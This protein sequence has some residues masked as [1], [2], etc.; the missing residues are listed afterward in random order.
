MYS[1]INLVRRASME[2]M[3]AGLRGRFNCVDECIC[4]CIRIVIEWLSR[5]PRYRQ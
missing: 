2:E 5:L 3:L 4:D 1:V